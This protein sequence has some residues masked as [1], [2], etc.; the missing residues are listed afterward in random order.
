MGLLFPPV[1]D[2]IV[3]GKDPQKA[4][5]SWI[6]WFQGVPMSVNFITPLFAGGQ[7]AS[8]DFTT[9]S[10]ILKPWPGFLILLYTTVAGGLTV[11]LPTSPANS[12][13]VIASKVGVAANVV[14]NST[15]TLTPGTWITLVSDGQ[16]WNKVM[17]GSL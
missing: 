12:I 8:L 5:D 17:G 6:E 15:Y 10:Q 16:N 13:V 14:I 4:S 1:R 9:G 7:N 11:K 3:R 2:H